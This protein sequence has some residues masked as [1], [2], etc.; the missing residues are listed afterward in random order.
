MERGCRVNEEYVSE[1]TAGKVKDK[2]GSLTALPIIE[3]QAGDVSAFVPTNVISI[4]DGQI[5]LETSYFNKGLLPAMNPG[6]SVS[7]VGGAAQ[8]PLIKKLGGG[9]RIA[10][11]QF[12]ELEAFAQF[13]SDLD[14]ASR[15]Q[16]EL[17]QKVTELMKQKQYSP[18]SV[19]EMGLVLFAVEKGYL[20]DIELNKIADFESALLSYMASE[21]KEF[22]ESLS[23]TGDYSDEIMQTFTDALE[24]FKSTQTF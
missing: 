5:F 13:A 22:M 19:A 24:K 20:K 15:E 14:D 4:T 7:R 21:H 11:A 17:G 8:T 23:E 12:R 9:V 1:Q 10:L 3:T 18:M 2:T 16:L 6:I